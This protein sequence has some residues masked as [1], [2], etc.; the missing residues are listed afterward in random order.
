MDF[1]VSATSSKKK[2]QN[3]VSK[4]VLIRDVIKPEQITEVLKVEFKDFFDREQTNVTETPKERR[5]R[6]TS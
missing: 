6:E 4:S 5:R 2:G 1:R 3:T